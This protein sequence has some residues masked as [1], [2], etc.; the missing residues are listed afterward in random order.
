MNVNNKS[1][2]KLLPS[3]V[4]PPLPCS[5]APRLPCSPCLPLRISPPARPGHRRGP[6]PATGRRRGR[7]HSR[8]GAALVLL[9]LFLIPLIAFLALA[10]DMGLLAVARTQCQNAADVAALAGVR[11]LNGN[12]ATNNNY[13]AVT[14][15][16]QAASTANTVLSTPLQTSQVSVNIGRYA[17]N[18]TTKQFEGQLPGSGTSNWSLVQSKVTLDISQS[19][20]F[21]R[22][23]GLKVP[24][25]QATA[26]AVHRPR[27]VALILDYSGSMRFATYPGVLNWPSNYVNN[28]DTNV[29]QFG[30]YSASAASMYATSFNL[31][32]LAANVTATTSDGRPPMCADFY[33]DG[34]G[35]PAFLAAPASY[36]A[37]PGGDNYL[38]VNK[39]QG[40]TYAYS[41][42]D[43]LNYSAPTTS[44]Y[45]S[46]FEQYGYTAYGMSPAFNG[47]TQGPGY[48][49]KT[50]FIWPPDPVDDWRKNYFTYPG[51]STPMDDNS[52]LWDSSGS[53]MA[54]G[55]TYSINYTAILN[56][57]KNIGP[58]PFPPQLQSGRI[59]YYTAIPDT[60][61]TSSDP[62][63][64]L[65]Q[66]FWKDYIDYVLGAS[67]VG[68]GY[69]LGVNNASYGLTGYGV[70]FPWG[71]PTITAKSSLKGGSKKTPYMFYGDNPQRPKLNFW[72]GP[73]TMVD[74]LE[75][76]M[77]TYFVSPVGS[78]YCWWPGTCHEAPMY[79]CKLG[80]QAALNDIYNNHPNDWV[81]EI[82]FSV[83]Q[84]SSNDA[85]GARFNRVRV[86]LGQNYQNMQD[87]LWYPPATVF[88]GGT[89]TPY[90]A[91]NLEVPRAF[92]GTCYAMPLMLAYNQFSGATA[93]LNYATPAG[94]AGGNGR[95]GAQ[96]II[97]FETDGAPNT[98]ATAALNNGGPYQSYY[99]VRYNM[100]NPGASEFPSGVAGYADN[101]PAVTSQIYT[102][103]QQL[104]ASDTAGP[105]GYSSGSHKLQIHCIGFGPL[106]A[107]GSSEAAACK[108]TLNQMQIIGNVNDGMPSYKIIDGD[109]NTVITDLQQAIN[110]IL[111]STIPVS[112]IQ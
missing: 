73:L 14:P 62:P 46:N 47:Y 16:A 100:S 77:L 57:I 6:A 36:G 81:S 58:N 79:A 84:Q 95:K 30:H 3:S 37:T 49:G 107:A 97:I 101:D 108:A 4:S 87:S 23:L 42:A 35:T 10:I 96:K 32:Y 1:H 92:G 110:K 38:K 68:G 104:A 59:V 22:V 9:L 54:P 15:A 60:I 65:N 52:Q 21:S 27:D 45:D 75:N 78:R 39:N 2:L 102:I 12:P 66:R 69:Y 109:Q 34:G 103:C 48:Y 85:S 76:P 56:F 41:V 11:T 20:V 70:D 18:T 64:D 31:P 28:A 61:D 80:I 98:T 88:G 86:G 93:C 91:N 5:P 43:L 90:D 33:Q 67:D 82:M 7:P 29:P 89:V 17:Y 53:W 19:M 50:F 83:P 94:D 99:S 71:T 55:V 74:F 13:A 106:F 25:L 8:R 112:L 26:T 40:S 105:P 63:V 72:F 111:E 51:S 24:T 44:T